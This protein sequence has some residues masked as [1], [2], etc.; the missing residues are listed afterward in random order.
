MAKQKIPV[1]NIA[2]LAA[3][4]L[5]PDDCMIEPF[6][7]YLGRHSPHLHNPHRHSFYHLV[8][9]TS[10]KGSHSIDFTRFPVKA[11]QVYFMTPGQVH[12]WNFEGQPGGYVINFSEGFLQSFLLNPQYLDRFSFFSGNAADSVVQ[13]VSPIREQVAALLEQ[14]VGQYRDRVHTDADLLRAELLQ[15]F[16]LVQSGIGARRPAASAALTQKQQL[17]T[18]LRKLMDQHYKTLRRPS[19]YAGLLYI[20]PNHLNTLCQDLLGRSAGEV[21]RDRVLLE[22]KRLLT[23][24]GMTATEIAYE[25]NFQDN[26][27]FNRFF[28]KY[29]GVTPEEFRRKNRVK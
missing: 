18:T 14:M 13:L 21:I 8:C 24:A 7:T 2:N 19:E 25:L 17:L 23:N 6:G 10:G 1:Y 12:S 22:A 29:E 3:R 26:S 11:G 16:L 20:T 9:F 5:D 28:K 27:Y 15:L 4:P